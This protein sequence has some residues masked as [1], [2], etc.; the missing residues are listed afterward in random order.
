MALNKS[1]GH[2]GSRTGGLEKF[3]EQCHP[4]DLSAMM[5]VFYDV[6]ANTVSTSHMCH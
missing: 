6:L 3:P 1:S 4:I 5:E 2:G